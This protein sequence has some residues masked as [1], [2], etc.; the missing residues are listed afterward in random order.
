[1]RETHGAASLESIREKLLPSFISFK[2]A[3]SKLPSGGWGNV[4]PASSQEGMRERVLLTQRAKLVG[5]LFAQPGDALV[6]EQVLPNLPYF[7]ERTANNADF[8][9]A[10]YSTDGSSD[11][12]AVKVTTIDRVK[13][14]YSAQ[15]LNR[16]RAEV[17]S[18]VTWRYSGGCDLLLTNARLDED[19]K[20]VRLDF[21]TS[22]ICPL[23]EMLRIE[24]IT[25]IPEFFEEIFRY[26]E[27]QDRNDPTWGLSDSP[28]FDQAGSILKAVVLSLLPKGVGKEAEKLVHLAAQDMSK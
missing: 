25:S 12:D 18:S 4:G 26:V 13:W 5:I 2:T 27:K 28:G 20:K 10:G 8:F 22:V 11:A 17:E 14:F 21:A 24:A 7:H 9:F 15:A 6:K 1:M 19:E 16:I 3:R 23:P